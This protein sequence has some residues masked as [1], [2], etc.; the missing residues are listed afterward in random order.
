MMMVFVELTTLDWFLLIGIPAAVIIVAVIFVFLSIRRKAIDKKDLKK[1]AI[2]V[3][4]SEIFDYF[5]GKENII[6]AEKK[7]SRLFV[8]LKDIS[9]ANIDKIKE[10][11]V[12]NVLVMSTKLVLI[13]Q[14][15]DSI[16][17]LIRQ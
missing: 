14:G 6:N 5:G 1:E 13:G 10:N 11:G 3:V 2:L 12:D 16:F 9:L 17:E 8:E 7:G 4:S 15:I